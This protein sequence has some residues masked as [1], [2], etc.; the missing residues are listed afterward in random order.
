LTGSEIRGQ[1]AFYDRALIS[2]DD[3]A[4]GEAMDL[5]FVWAAVFKVDVSSVGDA[6]KLYRETL[7]DL[8][9]DLVR[10]A[11][12]EL[13]ATWRWGNR[14]PLP[15]DFRNAVGEALERRQNT[16][17]VLG[18]AAAKLAREAAANDAAKKTAEIDKWWAEK[19]RARGMTVEELKA[20]AAAILERRKKPVDNGPLSPVDK[21]LNSAQTPEKP[22]DAI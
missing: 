12:K 11:V 22:H 7:K 17:R 1:L 16:R 3:R 19:A 15:A 18:M 5:L 9:G 2:A 14:L 10:K 8:P 13:T 21:V 4:W 20:E 6:A